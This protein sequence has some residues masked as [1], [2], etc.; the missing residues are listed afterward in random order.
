MMPM[1]GVVTDSG[2]FPGYQRPKTA[3]IPSSPMMPTPAAIPAPLPAA[4]P[5]AGVASASSA[6]FASL[7]R[8]LALV[9]GALLVLWLVLPQGRS[10]GGLV[11]GIT[12]LK[13]MPI[14]LLLSA[15]TV[16]L[17]G[18][19]LLAAGIVPVPNLG[20]AAIMA[21]GGLLPLLVGGVLARGFLGGA[22]FFSLLRLV[23][24]LALVTGLF[25]R[26]TYRS[27]MTARGV[28]AAG[29]V[30]TILALVI[31]V[32]GGSAV[33]GWIGLLRT[34]AASGIVVGIVG[35]LVLPL[36]ALSLLAFLPAPQ[37]GLAPVWAILI[38]VWPTLLALV[39][40][41]FQI[42]SIGD[43]LT[44]VGIIH[45]GLVLSLALACATLGLSQLLGTV[46]A[47]ASSR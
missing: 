27:S 2:P 40:A 19:V 25:L 11:I 30:L 46:E 23:G 22:G 36:C 21:A 8:V 24:F 42:G 9:S 26:F 3:T 33:G 4:G 45:R 34:G 31:P 35:L 12:S 38:L 17:G 5:G 44:L 14:L 15:L 39:A 32:G 7:G 47:G 28:V 29:A 13:G 37:S 1:P 41:V 16:P 10:S 6:I 43:I 20:R 18:L